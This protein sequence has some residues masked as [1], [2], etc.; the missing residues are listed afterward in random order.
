MAMIALTVKQQEKGRG[1]VFEIM[2]IFSRLACTTIW[3][4]LVPHMWNSFA[5]VQ[6]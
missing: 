6:S 1:N 5:G 3:S 2:P 4:E